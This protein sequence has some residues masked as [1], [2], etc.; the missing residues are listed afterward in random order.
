MPLIYHPIY[1]R[2][3][4]KLPNVTKIWKEL[5]SLPLFTEIKE[6]EINFILGKIKQF[7]NNYDKF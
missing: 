6:T 1:R 7:D 3:K 4:T 2:Y 5:V